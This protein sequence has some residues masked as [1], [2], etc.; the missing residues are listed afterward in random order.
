MG[1][2][3]EVAEQKRYRGTVCGVKLTLAG[4]PAEIV[5]DLRVAIDDRDTSGAAI[6]RALRARGVNSLTEQMVQR[7]RRGDCFCG[8]R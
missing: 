4:A 2:L 5:D 6:V 8:V 1:F 3:D 7:H